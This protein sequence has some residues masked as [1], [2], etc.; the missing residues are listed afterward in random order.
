MRCCQ[1]QD[2]AISAAAALAEAWLT[3]GDGNLHDRATGNCL[4]SRPD[5]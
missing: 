1:W 2:P 4:T 3:G 5:G